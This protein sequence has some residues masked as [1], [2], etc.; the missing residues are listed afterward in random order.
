[1]NILVLITACISLLALIAHTFVGSKETATLSP[2]NGI[3]GDK[4]SEGQLVYHW[5]Q[6]MCGFQM[7]TMDL[8]LV[9]ISLFIIALT[10]ILSF[11]YELTLFLSIVF[12]LWGVAWLVQLL[13]LKSKA[14]TYMVLAHW[15]VWFLCSGLLF[16]WSKY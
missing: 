9:T 3:E 1:M 10:D 13:W 15:V 12:F 16:F 6:A 2:L 11:E 8:L 4:T 7:L 5:K 14:K